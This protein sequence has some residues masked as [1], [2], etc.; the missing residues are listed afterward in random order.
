MT[1][2]AQ[3]QITGSTK[4]ILEG[5]SSA[6]A[7]PLFAINWFDTSAAWVYHLYNFLASSRLAKAGGR[8]YFKA[9]VTDRLLGDESLGRAH[10]LIVR[11]PSAEHFLS[12]VSD[13]VFQLFSVLRMVSVRNFSFV[14]HQ[15]R[16][17]PDA[18][19]T[20]LDDAYAVLHFHWDSRLN[21]ILDGVKQ[22][23]ESH[24]VSVCFASHRAVTIASQN[25]EN[26]P[27]L[28]PFETHTV[29]LFCAS[30]AQGIRS[31]FCSTSLQQLLPS[32]RHCFGAMLHRTV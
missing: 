29:M 18:I 21:P 10:L 13:K 12:L 16:Q 1:D 28:M 3:R 4:L 15:R 2:T 27:Q 26:D 9:Y 7:G 23:A 17:G 8:A 31:L 20:P 6:L 19:Q 24:E 5:D 14:M 32:T 30:D 11:Y 25:N 22:V